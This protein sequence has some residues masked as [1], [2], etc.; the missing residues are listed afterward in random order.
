LIDGS[1]K[2]VLNEENISKALIKNS[3]EKLKGN[4]RLYIFSCLVSP[5]YGRQIS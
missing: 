1:L 5:R 2:S 4:K 3:V